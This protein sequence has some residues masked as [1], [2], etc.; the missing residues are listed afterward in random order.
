MVARIQ[1][2]Q[3]CQTKKA[4]YLASRRFVRWHEEIFLTQRGI[5]KSS[6]DRMMRFIS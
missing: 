1:S 5:G 3:S 6:R 2:A 4:M